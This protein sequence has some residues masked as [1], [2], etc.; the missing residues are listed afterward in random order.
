MEEIE[1]LSS[2]SETHFSEFTARPL[3]LWATW[4]VWTPER[5]REVEIPTKGEGT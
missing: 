4:Q 2:L 5:K 1:K 3:E